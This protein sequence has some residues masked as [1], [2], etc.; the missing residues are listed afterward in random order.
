MRK[1]QAA[2]RFG[3]SAASAIRW[4]S[5][6]RTQGDVR[7]GPLGGDRRSGRIESHA[8]L[9]LGLLDGQTDITL[10]PE[11]EHCARPSSGQSRPILVRPAGPLSGT[12]GPLDARPAGLGRR[13]TRGPRRPSHLR[14]AGRA[15][16]VGDPG[17]QGGRSLTQS[18]V[19]RARQ[20][21]Q[22]R[23]EARLDRHGSPLIMAQGAPVVDRGGRAVE[24]LDVE[25]WAWQR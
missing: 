13:S 23:H 3:V 6:M 19:A 16:G 24:R 1:E 11:R 18:L 2:A 20:C 5:R 10:S 12:S 9:I 7:P 17:A 22:K 4:R 8:G 21:R 15:D 25:R 14:R